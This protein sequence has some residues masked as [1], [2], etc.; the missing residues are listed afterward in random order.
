[1][2]LHVTRTLI[3]RQKMSHHQYILFSSAASTIEFRIKGGQL[4]LHAGFP[5]SLCFG[6]APHLA[7]TWWWT[8]TTS[9]CLVA[10]IQKKVEAIFRVF[11]NGNI[12]PGSGLGGVVLG[13]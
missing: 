1:M 11:G 7:K 9:G 6:V 8:L 2:D 13:S 3:T 12:G 4:F 5:F 10:L